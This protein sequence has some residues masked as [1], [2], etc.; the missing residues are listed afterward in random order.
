MGVCGTNTEK[1]HL[2][3]LRCGFDRLSPPIFSPHLREHRL[4]NATNPP[5]PLGTFGTELVF[6][7]IPLECSL[8][9]SRVR[10][11]DF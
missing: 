8:V 6:G 3:I 2:V 9:P 7:A 4:T 1:C 10:D 11:Y 5:D